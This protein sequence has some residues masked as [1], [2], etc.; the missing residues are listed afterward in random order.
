MMIGLRG[1]YDDAGKVTVRGSKARVIHIGVAIRIWTR[2]GS[3]WPLF[4]HVECC[5]DCYSIVWMGA[6]HDTINQLDYISL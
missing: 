2:R 5:D 3:A 6:S 4:F 1:S